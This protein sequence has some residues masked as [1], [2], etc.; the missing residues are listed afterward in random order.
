MFGHRYYGRR[1]FGPR[2]W[3]D[4][5]DLEPEPPIEPVEE[6]LATPGYMVG[7]EPRREPRREREEAER[8]QRE[9]LGILAR[10]PLAPALEEAGLR[11]GLEEPGSGGEAVLAELEAR[12]LRELELE[13]ERWN[14]Q[15]MLLLLATV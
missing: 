7:R 14:E 9:K 2:Y 8:R 6:E 1:Y 10:E 5:G 3:G 12:A 15:A 11:S 4:G 13:Q